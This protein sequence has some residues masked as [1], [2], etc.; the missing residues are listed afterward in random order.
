MDRW[1]NADAGKRYQGSGRRMKKT[2]MVGVSQVL[3]GVLETAGLGHLLYEDKLRRNWGALMGE[4][5]AALTS[6]ESLKDFNLKV[7][8]EN[9]AWRNELHYQREAIKARANGLLGAELVREVI[10]Y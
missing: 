3:H 1:Y 8:V 9:A 5:A 2:P 6:L 7:K 10:L 4:R